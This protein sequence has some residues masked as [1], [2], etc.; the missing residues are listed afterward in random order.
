MVREETVNGDANET[1]P[2]MI[3]VASD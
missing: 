2:A 3:K 1:L